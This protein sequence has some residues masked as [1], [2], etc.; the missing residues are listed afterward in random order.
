MG[1]AIAASGKRR[2][3]VNRNSNIEFL[4]LLGMAC[5]VLNHFPWDYDSL[6]SACFPGGGIALFLVNLLSNFGGLGDCLFFGI[7]AWFLSEEIQGLGKNVKRVCMLEAQLL[8][9]GTI[10]FAATLAT[11]CAEGG[12]FSLGGLCHA[13]F[14]AFFPLMSSHWWY[15]TSYAIFLLLCPF[16]NEGLRSLDKRAHSL[17]CFVLLFLY[18][19]FPYSFLNGLIRFDMSYSVWLFVYQYVLITCLRWHYSEFLLNGRLG[20][21]LLALGLA[22]GIGTQILFGFPLLI[23]GKSMLSHQLWLNTPACLPPMFLALGALIIASTKN[24]RTNL[25]INKAATGTLAVYLI[26]TDTVASRLIG[27]AVGS[28]GLNGMAYM[29]FSL[30]VAMG[31]FVSCILFDLLRQRLMRPFSSMIDRAADWVVALLHEMAMAMY[32][33]CLRLGRD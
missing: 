28:L 4:R 32:G 13:L 26:L 7:S 33:K 10:L 25:I 17:L 23:M 21:R 2:S 3:A 27:G 14:G 12:S 29:M 22:L 1:S 6:S 31:V 9:Y 8:F 20:K 15:T 24:P 16:L 5:I 18:S 11:Q 30:A 19:L